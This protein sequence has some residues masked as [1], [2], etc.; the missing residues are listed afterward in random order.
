MRLRKKGGNNSRAK[1]AEPNKPLGLTVAFV[2][3]I[4]PISALRDPVLPHHRYLW[5]SLGFALALTLAKS[6]SFY[7]K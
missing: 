3:Q 7:K 1:A 5:L 2:F 4:C 6:E